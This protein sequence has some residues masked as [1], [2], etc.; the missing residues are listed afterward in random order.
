MGGADARAHRYLAWTQAHYPSGG[1][2]SQLLATLESCTREL[3]SVARYKN[4]VR[5]LRV[6]VQYVRAPRCACLA[7]PPRA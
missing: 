4:D 3:L 6:W 2:G 5:Y 7:S 1:P